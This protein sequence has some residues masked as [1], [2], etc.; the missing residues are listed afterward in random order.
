VSRLAHA[1]LALENNAFDPQSLATVTRRRDEIG[2]LARVFERM[3]LEVHARQ[4]R[5]EHQV[6]QLRIEID[7]AKRTR[8]VTEITETEY[9]QSLSQRARGLRARFQGSG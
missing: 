6:Q 7:D 1:A 8:E 2:H 4:Q 3:A 5:L 9:F